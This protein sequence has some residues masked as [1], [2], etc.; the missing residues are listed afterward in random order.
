[1]GFADEV[2]SKVETVGDKAE[3]VLDT[4]KDKASDVIDDLKKT[5][6][7]D[8]DGETSFGEVVETVETKAGELVRQGQRRH[9][10]RPGSGLR[11]GGRSAALDCGLHDAAPA[12][13]PVEDFAAAGPAVTET[14][15]ESRDD[16]IDA[17]QEEA[18][19]LQRHSQPGL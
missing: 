3:G 6:D 17:V 16:S 10:R 14:V 2:K 9:E 8:G 19:E 11:A 5:F 13:E 7:T 1:M 18:E 4:A 15:P 12:E